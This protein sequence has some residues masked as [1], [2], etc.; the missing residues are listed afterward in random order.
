QAPPNLGAGYVTEMIGAGINDW[1]G[2]SPVTPDHVNPEA[3]WPHLRRLEEAT[4]AAGKVL[5]ER[6]AI[7]PAYALAPERWLDSALRSTVL[8]MID[9]QGYARDDGWTPGA[10][11][12][13]QEEPSAQGRPT[14][15]LGRIVSRALD[16]RDLQEGDVVR[17]FQARGPEARHVCAAADGLRAAM[18][19]ETV[20]YV[21]NRNINYTNVCYFRC[22][23]CAFSKG[24]LSENL[25]GRPYVLGVEEVRRRTREAWERGATEV[26]MQG[27]IHPDYTGATYLDLC[28]SA[29]DAAPGIH[30]H[31]F[32]PLE[33]WQGAHT[34]GLPVADYLERLI[35]AGLGSLPGTAAE[36][37]DEEVRAVICPDKITT[38]QWLDVMEQAHGLGLRSTATIMFGHADLPAH[39]ARHLLQLRALQASTGGFTEFV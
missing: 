37:L 30:V 12:P 4:A 29:K 20:T 33:V 13:P 17:L 34:V 27:G 14:P 39:W 5:V 1:G 10:L 3:P 31:A 38:R 28:A 21:V 23:F 7:Y 26:C 8:R 24:R 11:A 2:I 25:R 36:I 32:S 18:S 35:G 16:G 19:G 9:T 22:Q 15:P 6:L